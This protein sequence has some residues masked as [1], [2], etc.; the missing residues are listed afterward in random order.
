MH[1]Y[2]KIADAI[3]YIHANH[4][5]QPSL[6]NIAA[7]VH[8]SPFHF[9]RLFTEWAGVSPKKF[10]QYIS[11]QH[12][13]GLLAK[14]YTVEQATFETG[15][16]G[17]SRLHDMFVNLEAMTPGEYRNGGE[18]LTI[19]YAFIDT[20]FGPMLAAATEKGVCSIAF[21]DDRAAALKELTLQWPNAAF[22]ESASPFIDDV[23]AYFS[24]IEAEMKEETPSP[25]DKAKS[26]KGIRL[27]VKATPFQLK[28]WEALLKVPAGQVATY[29][30]IAR[31]IDH[32]KA[33]RAVGTAVGDNPVAYLIPCHRVIKSTGLFG[34]YH[35]GPVRKTAM[36]GW[37]CAKNQPVAL[38]STED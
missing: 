34:G 25:A 15:L 5:G 38:S 26:E 18:A 27:H 28:V 30:R 21:A 32:P 29:S 13:K 31:E 4:T 17:T 2:N 14:D 8:L 3:A 1:H 16:S 37:E 19:R 7:A 12:A 20:V 36:L 10:L 23:K 11:L 6:D 24:G 9:Q 22:I 33:A 35:W